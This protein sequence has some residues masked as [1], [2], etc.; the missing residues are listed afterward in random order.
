MFSLKSIT[1]PLTMAYAEAIVDLVD[2][3][4]SNYLK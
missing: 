4:I 1:P 3:Q 2:V